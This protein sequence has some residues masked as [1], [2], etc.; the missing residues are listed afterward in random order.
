MRLYAPSVRIIGLVGLIALGGCGR[1]P[2]D[3][4]SLRSPTAKTRI[5]HDN[6]APVGGHGR[7]PVIRA[8]IEDLTNP[9]EAKKE[10]PNSKE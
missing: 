1:T 10:S 8:V 4:G 2:R 6:Q 9:R 3:S 5:E 7:D